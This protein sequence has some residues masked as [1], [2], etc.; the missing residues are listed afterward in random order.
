MIARGYHAAVWC[1][2]RKRGGTGSPA[3]RSRPTRRFFFFFVLLFPATLHRRDEVTTI[4]KVPEARPLIN[5]SSRPG[6][7]K[8][9]ESRTIYVAV[10]GAGG[11]DGLLRV[12]NDLVH[13]TG[14]TRQFVEDATRGSVPDVSSC[15]GNDEKKKNTERRRRIQTKRSEEPAVMRLPSGDQAQRRRFFSKLCCLA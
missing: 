14:V 9:Q 5:V 8:K 6:C 4:F 2:L 11:D 7:E 10:R 12:E 1:P 13:G 3:G 15:Q